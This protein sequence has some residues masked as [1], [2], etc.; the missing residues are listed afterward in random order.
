M[1]LSEE[2]RMMRVGFGYDAHRLVPGRPLILGGV[3][4]PYSLGLSGHSDADALTHA[5]GDALLGA[6]GAGDLGSH[7]P[8]SDPAYRGISSLILL[9]RIVAV[10]KSRG[11]RPVNVDITVVA[12]KPRLAPHIPGMIGKLSPVLGLPPEAVS[13]KAT[14]TERMGFTGRE[15]GI[16]AYAVVLVEKEA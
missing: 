5:V 14:T 15:E 6:V 1:G 7:F 3:E 9:E 12:E 10:V 8:D 13:L 11:Y 16:A 4:I 2:K